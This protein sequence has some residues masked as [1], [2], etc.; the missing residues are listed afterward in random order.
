MNTTKISNLKPNTAIYN[1]S[2]IFGIVVSSDLSS[3]TPTNIIPLDES[4]NYK[5]YISS[6]INLNSFK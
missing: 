2:K 1:T 3:N 5:N 6:Y 4:G